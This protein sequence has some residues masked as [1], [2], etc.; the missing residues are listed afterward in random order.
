MEINR[1]CEVGIEVASSIRRPRR[2][3]HEREVNFYLI[4]SILVCWVLLD[5]F[6]KYS[7]KLTD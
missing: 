5:V 2:Q 3:I 1:H 4:T 7:S 6:L